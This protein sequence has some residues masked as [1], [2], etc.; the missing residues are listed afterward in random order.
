M[1][2]LNRPITVGRFRWSQSYRARS[3]VLSPVLMALQVHFHLSSCRPLSFPLTLLSPVCFFF[4][5]LLFGSSYFLSR[6]ALSSLF[7]ALTRTTAGGRD[8]ALLRP[9]L[10][11]TPPAHIGSRGWPWILP[12]VLGIFGWFFRCLLSLRFECDLRKISWRNQC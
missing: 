1:L 6:S 11:R 9:S 10:N 3:V 5:A 7:L 12:V 4:L 8:G 2:G